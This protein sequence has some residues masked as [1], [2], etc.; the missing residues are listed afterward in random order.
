[1]SVIDSYLDTLFAPYAE[2]ARLREARGELRAMM[3]DK[4]ESLRADGLSESQAVGKVIAEFGTLDE[5]A[6]VL[7]LDSDFATPAEPDPPL[8][9]LQRARRY[10]TAIRSSQRLMALGLSLLVLCSAPLLL[11]LSISEL[12]AGVIGM[13]AEGVGLVLLFVMV[14]GGVML[15]LLRDHRLRDVQDVDD[16]DFTPSPEVIEYADALRRK[17]RVRPTRG[18]ALA[19]VLLILSSVPTVI[20]SVIRGDG[21]DSRATLIGVALTLIMAA[22]GL[23]VLVTRSWGDVAAAQL[24]NPLPDAP[25]ASSSPTVRLI[26]AIYWPVATA[27]FLAWGFLGDAWDRSWIVILIAGVL[28]GAFWAA[29]SALRADDAGPERP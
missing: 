26:A 13:T 19:L 6:P 20:S 28:S 11:L 14:A 9:S 25:A 17:H 22:A 4:Q 5:V 27:I 29:A 2:T 7:G 15:I 8:L 12:F 10:T 3:E 24:E 21:F 16:G 1:M 23:A 18:L